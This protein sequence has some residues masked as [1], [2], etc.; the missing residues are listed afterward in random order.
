MLSED[1]IKKIVQKRSDLQRQI[2]EI[3]QWLELGKKL[4]GLTSEPEP[5]FPEI[6]TPFR[7]T[8]GMPPGVTPAKV[9]V[10]AC[11]KFVANSDVPVPVT[12]L[13]SAMEAEGYV[14][15]GKVPTRNL[16]AKLSQGGGL[17]ALRGFGYWPE[18]KPYGPAGYQPD[19]PMEWPGHGTATRARLP[20]IAQL[21]GER[22]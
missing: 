22:Q 17:V 16:S 15:G 4:V 5:S 18:G 20:G 3:D 14:L 12:E 10:E 11:T 9:L 2:E 21:K 6:P 7:E 8:S 13:A 1:Q 19:R